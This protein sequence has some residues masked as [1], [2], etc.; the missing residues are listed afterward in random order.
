METGIKEKIKIKIE[1]ESKNTPT[2]EY[3]VETLEKFKKDM[4]QKFDPQFLDQYDCEIVSKIL[5][6]EA[7]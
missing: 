6:S 7:K 2:D 1:I 5:E 3:L 4:V